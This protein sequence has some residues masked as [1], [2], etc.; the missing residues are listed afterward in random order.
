M[1]TNVPVLC[2]KSSAPRPAL[3]GVGRAAP[4]AATDDPGAPYRSRD[5]GIEAQS[6]KI[7]PPAAAPLPQC[8][9][10]IADIA[11]DADAF[12]L[13]RLVPQGRAARPN[14]D[15]SRQ[16]LAQRVEGA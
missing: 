1:R 13:P 9:Q 10:R 15:R 14:A 6:G 5:A 16:R 11:D 2:L 7:G 4:A 12:E 3:H 8:F